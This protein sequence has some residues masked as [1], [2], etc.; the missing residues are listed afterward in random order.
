MVI[1][2]PEYRRL[3]ATRDPPLDSDARSGFFP[4]YRQA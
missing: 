2:E 4:L 3:V 1:D